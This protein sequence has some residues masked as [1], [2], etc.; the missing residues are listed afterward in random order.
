[1]IILKMNLLFISSSI[2]L[3][4]R[5]KGYSCSGNQPSGKTSKV[6]GLE[7]TTPCGTVFEVDMNIKSKGSTIIIKALTI[8]S[9]GKCQNGY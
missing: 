7:I 8:I 5:S 2:I 4:P 3:Y 1:M 6:R 9:I